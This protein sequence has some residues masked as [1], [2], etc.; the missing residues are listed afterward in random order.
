[1]RRQRKV[2]VP[3]GFDV[4][5]LG[6]RERQVL[7]LCEQG[8]SLRE[9]ADR[10]GVSYETVKKAMQR[11]HRRFESYRRSSDYRRAVKE[12]E[13]CLARSLAELYGG[14]MPRRSYDPVTNAR[15]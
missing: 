8:L 15:G 1:M 9:M 2:T 14:W 11:L 4:S 7:G 13:E 12:Q 5:R 6:W 10:L 3:V